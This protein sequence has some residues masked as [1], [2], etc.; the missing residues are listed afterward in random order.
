MDNSISFSFKV[1]N[2]NFI[3][4][5]KEKI[6]RQ[7]LVGHFDSANIDLAEKLYFGGY[8]G[9]WQGTADRKWHKVRYVLERPYLKDLFSEDKRLKES[10]KPLLKAYFA[11]SVRDGRMANGAVNNIGNQIVEHIKAEVKN[12][13]YTDLVP[14]PEDVIEGKGHDTPLIDTGNFIDSLSFRSP[15]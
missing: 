1:K 13:F 6:N 12:G 4:K 9:S 5:I 15:K 2:E 10:L 3:S 14:N 7:I 8:G 11:V